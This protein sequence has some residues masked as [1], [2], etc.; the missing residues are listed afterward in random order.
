[1][2]PTLQPP[3]PHPP[4]ILVVDDAASNRKMMVRLLTARGYE[5]RQAEDGQQ[6]IEMYQRMISDSRAPPLA[7][8]MDYEMPVMNGPT[9]TRKLREMGCAIPIIGVTGNL[10]PDDIAHFKQHGANEVMGKPLNIVKFEEV[11]RSI[12]GNEKVKTRYSG[13]GRWFDE[14]SEESES[15]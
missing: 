14:K 2:R 13:N 10:L 4:R 9:A 8:L 1:M 3:S 11:L 15:D 5:C 12:K 6:G 7:I